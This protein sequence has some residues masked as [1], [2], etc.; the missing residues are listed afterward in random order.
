MSLEEA[1]KL[2][3]VGQEDGDVNNDG[4]HGG[5][6]D[7]YLLKRRKAVSSASKGSKEDEPTKNKDET[8]VMN[9]KKESKK[10]ATTESVK[11]SIRERLMSVL[12]GNKHTAGATKPEEHDE[13]DSPLAK[14]MRDDHKAVEPKDSIDANKGP[15]DDVKKAANATKPAP[16]RSNDSKIGDKAII[17]K[18]KEAYASMYV[19]KQEEEKDAN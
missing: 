5:D 3:A 2:D 7:K 8:A 17:N 9:P 14:K 1:K 11:P 16:A 15:V 10:S 4:K 19:P 6:D 12:E 18:V 13:K